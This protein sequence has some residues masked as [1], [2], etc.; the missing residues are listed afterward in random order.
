MASQNAKERVARLAARRFGRV[1][2]G[3]LK[4][5]DIPDSTIQ[6]WTTTGY[7]HRVLPGVYAVGHRGR[8]IEADLAAAVLYAGPGAMLSHATAAWWVGLADSKPYMTDVSTPRRCRSLPGIRVHQRRTIDRSFHRRLPV[9]PFTQTLIDYASQASL[10]KVR[11]ALAEADYH[12]GVDVRA[13]TTYL[14]S[15]RTGSVRLRQALAAH[16]PALALARSQLEIM[17]FELCE[18]KDF[19]LP[20]LN[21]DVVG[22]TVDAVW[23]NERVAVEVDAYGNHR[24]PA[25]IRRDRLKDFD[26][27]AVGFAVLRYSDEQLESQASAVLAEVSRTLT[28][29]ALSA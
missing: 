22:W 10:S 21:A 28:R 25:Q 16:Q 20:E 4:W 15:G 18:A 12:G 11:R 14:G 5:L 17:L 1:S 13:I 19:P 29:P 23:R 6:R 8:T 26:L 24:T 2:W 27:R 7:L 9:T 3:Q